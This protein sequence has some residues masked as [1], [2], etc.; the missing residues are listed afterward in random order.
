MESIMCAFFT[1]WIFRLIALNRLS[2]FVVLG[3]LFSCILSYLILKGLLLL[4]N[5]CYPAWFYHDHAFDWDAQFRTKRL[6]TCECIILFN[7]FCPAGLSFYIVP[8]QGH[9]NVCYIEIFNTYINNICLIKLFFNR[10]R[11]FWFEYFTLAN[12]YIIDKHLLR[13][14]IIFRWVI[15]DICFLRTIT[16]IF[17]NELSTAQEIPNKFET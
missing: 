11:C 16:Q 5:N 2:F 7:G 9:Y 12:Y 13:V 10:C 14:E 15:R 8:K 4:T 6:H 17:N 1:S 3:S